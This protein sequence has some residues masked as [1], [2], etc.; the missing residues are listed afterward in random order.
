MGRAILI[1][2]LAM[3]LIP[4]G[5]MAGKLLTGQHG[6]SPVFVA[7]SRFALGLLVILPFVRA[8][9]LALLRNWR[10]W[11]RA[12]L[13][14]GGILS[15]QSALKTEPLA[16]VFAAFFVGPILSY[17]L[18]A[19]W[20]R[21]PV[22]WTRSAL[23]LVGF[24]GVLLVVRPGLGG[25]P[26][27]LLALLAGC[28]YGAFLTASRW[29]SH[30]G[31]PL[32]LS[33]TQL[34]IAGLVLTPFG[35]ANLPAL[36]MQTA[37]LTLASAMGSMLGNLLLLVAYAYA[38]ATRLAPLVYFQLIAAAGLGWAV[39]GDLPD[40]WTWAGLSLVLGAGLVSALLRR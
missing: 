6:V 28:F 19:L 33:F 1:M 20:L 35:I 14:A 40:L 8:P 31:T 15:I 16:N 39:F 36:D 27:L 34:A 29:L 21:E 26:G 24:L 10:V 37:G 18:S 9:A 32:A 5:D 38:P 3:S 17:A 12:L 30:L 7:W 11:L 23:M 2:F 25:S 13:L 22:T 4:A